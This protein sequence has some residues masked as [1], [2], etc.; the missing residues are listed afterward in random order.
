MSRKTESL[1]TNH[2]WAKLL[3]GGAF[4]W[5]AILR[6]IRGIS[7]GL[8]SWKIG[9]IDLVD[10]TARVDLQLEIKNPLIVGVRIKGIKGDVYVQDVLT[11]VIDMVYDYNISGAHSHVLPISVNLD[12]SS[13]SAAAM[14]NIESGNV[15]NL[16][17]R[18]DGEI[19]I[20]RYDVGVPVDITLNWEDMKA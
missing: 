9:A 8:Y 10:R 13:V 14:A 19:A 11:G 5:Y 4:L 7:V 12:L 20:S 16:T 17:I 18:F 6:G 15:E 2:K 1:H 3:A